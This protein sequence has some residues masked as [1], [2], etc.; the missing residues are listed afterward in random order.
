MYGA[1]CIGAVAG[2]SF[3]M[4]LNNAWFYLYPTVIVPYCVAGFLAV[5]FG[6]LGCFQ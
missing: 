5:C 4:L 6:T 1:I 3:G 2:F